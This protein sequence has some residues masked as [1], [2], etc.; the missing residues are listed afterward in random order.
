[1]PPVESTRRLIGASFDLLTRTSDD[2]RRA[3]FYIGVV[4]LVTLG[5]FALAAWAS[6][7][8]ASIGRSVR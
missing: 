4:M 2:M 6:R 7:S 3:S 1:M 8:S 5:P